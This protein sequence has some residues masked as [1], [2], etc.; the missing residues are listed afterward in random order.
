[1]PIIEQLFEH[2]VVIENKV[3]VITFS[4]MIIVIFYVMC[5]KYVCCDIKKFM[6]C[7]FFKAV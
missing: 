7:I 3:I 5:N 1:M 6:S 2:A 4:K